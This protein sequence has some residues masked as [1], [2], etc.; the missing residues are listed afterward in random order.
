[1]ASMPEAAAEIGLMWSPGRHGQ[2]ERA[3]TSGFM[4]VAGA[5]GGEVFLVVV[6]HG[7]ERRIRYRLGEQR[8]GGAEDRV[9]AGD[10]VVEEGQWLARLEAGGML[11]PVDAEQASDSA[12]RAGPRAR[13]R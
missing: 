10:V 6:E 13:Q 5:E 11:T 9:A 2:V 1:M 7:G 4:P 8:R 12:D 3:L